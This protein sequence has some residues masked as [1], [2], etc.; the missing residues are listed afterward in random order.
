MHSNGFSLTA[1]DYKHVLNRLVELGSERGIKFKYLVIDY[2]YPYY[3]VHGKVKATVNAITRTERL[4]LQA[5]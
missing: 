4:I 3:V 5:R 1:P 2:P